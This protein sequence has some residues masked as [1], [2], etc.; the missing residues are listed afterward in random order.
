MAVSGAFT[1]PVGGV[2][3]GAGN[4]LTGLDALLGGSQADTFDYYVVDANTVIG[5]EVDSNQN[6]LATFD[7]TQ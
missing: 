1:A 4:T 5:I 3:T 6:T 2:S 7:L